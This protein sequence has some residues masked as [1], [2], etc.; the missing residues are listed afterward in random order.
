MVQ[1][2][3]KSDGGQPDPETKRPKPPL[4]WAALQQRLSEGLS[5]IL[6]WLFD[7]INP[8]NFF[9]KKAQILIGLAYCACFYDNY[10][11]LRK[12]LLI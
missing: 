4:A 5:Y 7:G 8:N 9:P 6:W 12:R 10:S 1:F 2:Y 11:M 3:H